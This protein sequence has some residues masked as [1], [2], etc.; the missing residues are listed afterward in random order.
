MNLKYHNYIRLGWVLLLALILAIPTMSWFLNAQFAEA[1]GSSFMVLKLIGQITGIIGAQ[2]FAF[3]LILSGRLHFVEKLFGGL[4]KLYVIHH[5][6]GVISFT[7]LLIHPL[8]LAGRYV[9]QSLED[10]A[11]FLSPFGNTTP[12]TLG[13]LSV[14]VMLLLIGLTFYGSVFEYPTLKFAHRFLGFGFFL[15]FLHIFLIPSSLSSDIVLKVS[16]LSTALIGIVIFSYRT[17]LGSFVVSRFNYN[18]VSVEVLAGGVTE[19]LLNT[20]GKKMYHLPGQFGMLS[21]NGSPIVSSEEHAFTFSSPGTDGYVR[22]SIKGLG[23]YTKALVAMKKGE[24]ASIEGPFGEFCY[25]YGKKK[26]VWVAGGIGVTPFVS[27]AES[28]MF[29]ETLPY[30]IDF[31]YSVRTESEA[32]YKD[33]FTKIAKKHPSFNFYFMPSDTEGYITGELL[34]TEIKDLHARDIFVCGPP[35][36]MRTLDTQL[37]ELNVSK[38]NIH[39]ETFSLLK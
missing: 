16:L 33:L 24:K 37:Q 26:Q 39:M 9:T 13:I 15:G 30:D 4:D 20:A 23:D 27:M 11:S 17:L 3:S 8:V 38:N 18:V 12:I 28:M 2:L 35:I 21:F 5:Q 19:I 36:L 10:V 22:F 34:L 32:V 31:F 7:L 29:L 25:V 6:V 1:S 14:L